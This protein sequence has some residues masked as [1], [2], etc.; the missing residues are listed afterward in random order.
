MAAYKVINLDSP[1]ESDYWVDIPVRDPA[2]NKDAVDEQGRI[3]VQRHVTRSIKNEELST[4]NAAVETLNTLKVDYSSF[5]EDVSTKVN[6][7]DSNILTN[8]NNITT[9]T[10]SVNNH[11]LQ[12]NALY[13]KINAIQGI[14]IDDFKYV[15]ETDIKN[16]KKNY[17][18]LAGG[19]LTGNV[20]VIGS[21]YEVSVE[22]N[23]NTQGNL[24]LFA[25]DKTKGLYAQNADKTSGFGVIEIDQSSATFMG[26]LQ[27]TANHAKSAD[28]ATNA[29]NAANAAKASQNASGHALA[30]TIVKAISISGRTITVTKLDGQT[31]TLTTQDTNTTYSKLSQFTN[32]SGYITS[33]GSCASANYLNSKAEVVYGVNSLNYFNVRTSTTSGAKNVANPANDWYY[34]LM[35]NHGDANGYY[36]DIACAF[37]QNAMYYRR[38]ANGSEQTWIRLIDSANIGSQSVNYAK[39]AGSVA[40]ANVSGRPSSFTPSSHTHDDRYYTESEIDTKLGKLGAITG[41]IKWFTFNTVP[42]GYII[43]NGAKVSRKTYANLFAVIGTK[44]G[45]GDGSTTFDLPDLIDKFAQGSRTVGT[46]KRAGLPNITGWGLRG[47]QDNIGGGAFFVTATERGNGGTVNYGADYSFDASRS[48]TIYGNSTTVQPPALTLLPCIKY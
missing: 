23:N 9:L 46:Y 5:K 37:H 7:H 10:D 20:K 18:P 16:I 31:Y 38:V 12:I 33:S 36:F 17:L 35:M 48:N 22:V 8:T 30:D 2:T 28:N 14:D 19:T 32:D 34:H 1:I 25:N 13:T 15:T 29:T 40:W 24:F 26:N 6:S 39:S 27:G 4:F 42:D 43:C 21:K 44:F 3:L 41:E 11:D 45:S 47:G